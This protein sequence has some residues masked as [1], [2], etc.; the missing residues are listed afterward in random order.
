MASELRVSPYK[1]THHVTVRN[2]ISWRTWQIEETVVF[3]ICLLKTFWETHT[4][5]IYTYVVFFLFDTS[6]LVYIWFNSIKCIVIHTTYFGTLLFILHDDM[7]R[8]PSRSFN[9]NIGMLQT[10]RS[11]TI[12]AP[13][14]WNHQEIP[15]TVLLQHKYWLQIKYLWVSR[16]EKE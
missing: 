12:L 3:Y 6:P 4:I 7:F 2:K 1:R 13:R 16:Q 15:D 10:I 8:P 14:S 11:L 5:Y 9:S